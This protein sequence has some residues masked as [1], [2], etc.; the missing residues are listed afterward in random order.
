MLRSLLA[1]GLDQEDL[2]FPHRNMPLLFQLFKAFLLLIIIVFL[3]GV[4]TI[5][6]TEYNWSLKYITLGFNLPMHR[7]VSLIKKKKKTTREAKV[8]IIIFLIFKCL[9]SR[10]PLFIANFTYFQGH[11][12][13]LSNIQFFFKVC[14]LTTFLDSATR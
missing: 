2:F 1:C 14:L 3:P 7:K 5:T 11:I 13:G 12:F 8:N 4:R 10:K 9:F 6:V